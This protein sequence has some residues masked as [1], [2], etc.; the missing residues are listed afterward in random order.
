MS[1]S[2]ALNVISLPA[3]KGE[4]SS[5]PPDNRGLL[6]DC[7]AYAQAIGGYHA[8]F[9]AEVTGDS[10]FAGN[11]PG[12]SGDRLYKRACKLL[13]TI[14]RTPATTARELQAKARIVP[15]ILHDAGG[16]PQDRDLEF[17]ASFASE[18]NDF[19]DPLI[20]P[21]QHQG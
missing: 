6:R 3:P 2:S 4:A 13:V 20:N 5:P 14:G 15:I 18:V 19:L 11:T 9:G 1:K 17:F 12:A 8:G 10:D 16:V 21:T 7:V